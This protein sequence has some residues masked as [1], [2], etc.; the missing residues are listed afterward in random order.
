M[1]HCYISNT[2]VKELK[3]DIAARQD[4]PSDCLGKLQDSFSKNTIQHSFLAMSVCSLS[5]SSWPMRE[6]E[7]IL[8]NKE[9]KSLIP[10]PARERLF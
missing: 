8:S 6:I 7:T 4:L 1:H 9:S 5:S 10:Q 3:R 2:G